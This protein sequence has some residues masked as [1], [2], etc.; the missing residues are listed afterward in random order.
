MPL[1]SV[2]L[3]L[4]GDHDYKCILCTGSR[5]VM[6]APL[7]MKVDYSSGGL[8]MHYKRG[9]AWA[10]AIVCCALIVHRCT[11]YHQYHCVTKGGLST[12]PVL[13]LR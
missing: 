11:V 8:N 7:N 13:G 1:H 2:N 10:E 6:H 9:V 4:P 12:V 3:N 5:H